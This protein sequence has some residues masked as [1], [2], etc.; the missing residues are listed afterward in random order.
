MGTPRYG[1]WRYCRCFVC[2]GCITA[3]RL[4]ASL[5]T[6]PLSPH[7]CHHAADD[8]DA[9]AGRYG[10]PHRRLLW[11]DVSSPSDPILV[12]H[13]GDSRQPGRVKEKDRLRLIDIVDIRAGRVG[14]VLM[15]SGT[16]EEAGKYISFSGETRTL[17]MELPSVEARDFVFKKFADMFQA[18]ATAQIEKL[19][20]DAVTLRVAAIVDGGANN[21]PGS[22]AAPPP[23]PPPP[24]AQQQQAMHGRQGGGG[25]PMQMGGPPGMMGGMMPPGAMMQQYGSPPRPGQQ[26]QPLG[27]GGGA[28]MMAMMPQQQ[29]QM[30]GGARPMDLYRS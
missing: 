21:K 10:R 9:Y 15:R 13:E 18:Y 30:G 12:W 22:T 7:F 29:L 27:M 20:G 2:H 24:P 3:I 6:Q 17:D 1:C 5:P 23:P 28:G 25:L 14:A 11:L 26:Q 4:P 19:N 16:E 8:D